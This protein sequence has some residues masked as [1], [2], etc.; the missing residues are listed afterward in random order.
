[1]NAESITL[2]V[3]A[4]LTGPAAPWGIA[5][6]QGVKILA[7][8]VNAKGGLDVGGKKY[9]VKVIA[10][11]DKYRAADA[12]GAYSRLV[13]QDGVKYV[14]FVGSASTLAVKKNLEDDKV[15][16][17]TAAV[18]PKI[19]DGD[20]NFMFHMMRP[21]SDFIPPFY[22]W[23]KQNLTARRVAIINPN[24]ETGWDETKLSDKLFQNEG[25]DVIASEFLERDQQDLQPVLTK[26]LAKAPEIIELGS[27]SPATAGL[28]VRSARELGYKGIFTKAGASGPKEIVA[29]AGK[30]AA[31]GTYDVL[32][33]DPNSEGYKLLAEEYRKNIGQE[34]NEVVVSYYDAA[35]ALLHAIQA[36]GDVNDTAKIS[37]SFAKAL[38]MDSVQGGKLT[39]RGILN[40]E[41]MSD[42]FVG[43]IKNGES[44]V[45][46][47]IK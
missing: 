31:E 38:P 7:D 46:G 20:S 21:L 43:S 13:T 15:I 5:T 45:V 25:F 44:V 11:D 34:P 33:V 30:E 8:R 16:G 12:V 28:I 37:A 9:D 27:T 18:S 36:A 22:H 39:L 3:I 29:A 1:M 32:F 35:N 47:D 24:D 23:I 10:Y 19:F 40:H 42:L 4:P 6:A 2:G 41:I 26:I 14:F 17:L